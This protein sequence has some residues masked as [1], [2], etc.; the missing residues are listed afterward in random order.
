MTDDT[1]YDMA[2]ICLNGH[3]INS[4]A[5]S[6]PQQNQEFCDEC[7]S[8]TISECPNCSTHI[9]G[10]Y[11]IPGVMAFSDY[12]PPKFCYK[13][14]EP[15]SWTKSKLN[16]AKEL[17]DEMDN[18]TTEERDILKQSLDDLVIE[19]PKVQVATIRFKKLMAKAGRSAADAFR[20]ILVD[21]AS[22]TAKKILWP[23][24]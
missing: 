4:M 10:V 24:P 8:K 19:T 6:Y 18:L 9:K 11:H 5:Q 2:Q 20:D 17:A 3:V 1:W 22:E 15:F 21:I 13:C 16:A 12:I 23:E 7:G 14:G